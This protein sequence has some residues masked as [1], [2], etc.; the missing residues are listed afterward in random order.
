MQVKNLAVRARLRSP[1]ESIDLG[2]ALA[3]R[4]W[5]QLFIVW[6]LPAATLLTLCYW[7]FPESPMLSGL[8]IWWLKPVFD[9]LPLFMISRALFGSPVSV[10][11]ALRHFFSPNRRDWFLW[12]TLRRLSP[13]RS[14]DMPITVLEQSGGK[15]RSSRIGVLHRKHSGAATWLTLTLY[16]IEIF[17]LAA[18]SMLAFLFIPEQYAE[19]IEWMPLL[20]GDTL[21]LEWLYNALYLLIMAAVAPFYIVSGFCLY[22]GRRIELEGWDIEIQF[23]DF[24]ER[25]QRE[26]RARRRETPGTASLILLC[27]LALGTMLSAPPP[28]NAETVDTPQQGQE[29]IDEILAGEDFHQMK[30]I[31]GWRKKEVDE[32]KEKFPQ[33]LIDFIEWLID[34][35]EWLFERSPED[36]ESDSDFEWGPE[37]AKILELLFW[38]GL[39]GGLGYFGWKHREAILNSLQWHSSP[40]EQQAPPETLFGLDVRQSSLPADVCAEVMRLWASGDKRASLGLLYRATLSHLIEDFAFYFG[41]HLTEGECAQLVRARQLETEEELRPVSPTLSHFVQELTAN[42]QQLAYAHRPPAEAQ[43]STLCSQWQE[44]FGNDR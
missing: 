14:F 19:G 41:D 40:K 15:A 3:R 35:I 18:L 4:Y 13:T 42:W 43:V 22:I 21:W 1:W 2:I 7:L 30:E 27:S 20:Q 8:F 26:R 23:R 31:S 12:L 24:L 16:H 10:G 37:I 25:Q 33:W 6:L 34:F 32:V 44:E 9:R 11:T 17:L 29:R 5:W 39:I 28:A 36:T 38:L